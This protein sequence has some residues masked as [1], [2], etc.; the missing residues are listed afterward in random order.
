MSSTN[1][2]RS[3]LYAEGITVGYGQDAVLPG[4]DF[5]VPDGELTVILGPNACGKST[6]LKTLARVLTPSAGKIFLHG[7]PMEKS[8]T[9]DIARVM[10][11][12]PQSPEAPSGLCVADVVAR[13][14]YPHQSL[15]RAWTDEDERA[16][17]EAMTAAD[18]LPLRERPLEA[19][20]GGQRQ[21]VWIAMTL[22]QDTPLILL[23]EPTTYLDI[24]HQIEVLNLTRR[25]H[26]SGRTIVMV[27]HDLN[28]AFRYATRVVM[29]R[30]GRIIS[31]GNPRE[32]VD[33]ELVDQVFGLD[34]FV[35]R[36]PVTG[37]PMVVPAESTFQG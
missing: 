11:M 28:L 30:D 16:C 10:A 13:G 26:R 7:V 23:D 1:T 15:L 24:T 36:D 21:R 27:L 9:K 18:V 33:A 4:I 8:R 22:A 6:L 29:M 32:I 2:W 25:L 31:Q 17:L 20:S 12:L 34:A 3:N 14:R 35:T 19:L 5:E 37:A